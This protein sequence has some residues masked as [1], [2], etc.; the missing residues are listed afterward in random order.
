MWFSRFRSKLRELR[1]EVLFPKDGNFP[2]DNASY[3]RIEKSLMVRNPKSKVDGRRRF[4][5]NFAHNI[6]ENSWLYAVWYCR[7]Q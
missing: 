3:T 6:L 1:Q 2:S 5:E 7:R 4:S